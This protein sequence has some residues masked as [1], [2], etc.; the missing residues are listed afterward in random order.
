MIFVFFFDSGRRNSGF[1]SGPTKNIPLCGCF[2]F[3][4]IKTY[5][6]R[7]RGPVRPM[8]FIFVQ[9]MDHTSNQRRRRLNQPQASST[10]KWVL[11][12]AN[13]LLLD[14]QIHQGMLQQCRPCS[15]PSLF[16]TLFSPLGWSIGR[17][18]KLKVIDRNGSQSIGRTSS[19]A[20]S[21]RSKWISNLC[22]RVH[23]LL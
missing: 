3:F 22:R 17:T 12:S 5:T 7:F 10:I 15:P 6:G 8:T 4:S 20:E 2:F 11:W 23:S 18:L 21:H 16:Q 19:K 13:K 14:N 9:S 1:R